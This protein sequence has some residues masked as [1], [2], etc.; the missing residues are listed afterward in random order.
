MQQVNVKSL[1]QSSRGST[2]KID[3]QQCQ[4]QTEQ[5]KIIASGTITLTKTKNGIEALG[6]LNIT[7]EAACDRCLKETQLEWEI[8][9]KERFSRNPNEKGARNIKNDTINLEGA[10]AETGISFKPLLT[11]CQE[12]CKGLCDVCGINLNENPEHSH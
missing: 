8:Q 6:E 11:Y 12:S 2:Q 1:L 4:I 3:L 5:E 7:Q 10:I 9:L